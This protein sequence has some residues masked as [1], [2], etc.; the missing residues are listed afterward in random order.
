VVDRNGKAIIEYELDDGKKR[1]A[2]IAK[3]YKDVTNQTLQEKGE[4]WSSIF[5]VDV[6]ASQAG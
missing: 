1:F 2:S 6:M 3:F 5:F 4:S